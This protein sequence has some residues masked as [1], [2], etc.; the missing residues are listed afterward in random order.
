MAD[1][2][3]S[4]FFS[5]CVVGPVGTMAE[6][7]DFDIF[8]AESEDDDKVRTS[9]SFL[10]SFCHGL[11]NMRLWMPISFG[12]V[13]LYDMNVVPGLLDLVTLFWYRRLHG[14]CELACK[15]YVFSSDNL[16]TDLSCSGDP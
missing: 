5:S 16:T 14:V 15:H 9:N 11:R 10:S 3:L 6:S 13:S 12:L 7:D 8:S 1:C 4:S 2:L